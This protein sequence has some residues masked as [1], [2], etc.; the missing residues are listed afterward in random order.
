MDSQLFGLIGFPLEHSFSASYFTRK[1]TEEKIDAVYRNYPLR[2]ITEFESL[3]ESEPDLKG[4]NVTVPYK[5]RIIP[6]L[7]S[8]DETARSIQ[9]VNTI[10]FYRQ[11]KGKKLV[12]SSVLAG[13]NTDVT[14]FE[15]SLREHLGDR[16]HSALVLGT[17]G[18]SKAVI[19]VLKTMG[20]DFHRVSRNRGEDRIAYEE[21]DTDL[22][23]SHQLI[24][25]TT[26]LGMY[27]DLDSCP[28]IPYDAITPGHLLFDLVY[29]PDKT[30]FLYLGEQK[31]A[32]IVNGY[33]M[34]VY[35]AEA[36]WEIW[37]RRS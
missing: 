25:N 23:K 30:R 33:D 16:H 29:N 18:S 37:N 36:S 14:G 10:C 24:V 20:M 6:Y 13:F 31:G 26:P 12:G 9:A 28:P 3:V 35:Q 19:H 7:D 5:E 22:V 15:R 8:L 2:D 27:P 11:K 32:G 21:L 1:F 17:G 4:L 34:L